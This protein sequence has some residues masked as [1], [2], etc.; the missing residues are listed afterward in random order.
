V[1]SWEQLKQWVT[2]PFAGGAE[3]NKATLLEIPLSEVAPRY[4]ALRRPPAPQKK[5][6]VPES[7]PGLFSASAPEVAAPPAASAPAPAPVQQPQPPLMAPLEQAP[8]PGVSAP[9]TA[10]SRLGELLGR[11]EQTDWT[12]QEVLESLSRVKGI[13]GAMV[14]SQEGLPVASRLAAS[15]NSDVV[16]A[17]APRLFGRVGQLAEE[18]EM[19]TVAAA[20]VVTEQGPCGIFRAGEL[21]LVAFG[22]VGKELPEALLREIALEMRR[23]SL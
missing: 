3:E 10:R 21:Y 19:G 15:R 8:K 22:Q 13:Q 20:I 7:I 17:F 14:V 1:F 6:I 11:Q 16:A 2:P 9:S 18:M 23:R 12:P 5:V 4:M